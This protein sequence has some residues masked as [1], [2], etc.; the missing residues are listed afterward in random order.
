MKCK[1]IENNFKIEDF[2]LL[3]IQNKVERIFYAEFNLICYFTK[4]F[5]NYFEQIFIYINLHNRIFLIKFL[6]N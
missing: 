1:G 6:F 5:F 3:F 4:F 2:F